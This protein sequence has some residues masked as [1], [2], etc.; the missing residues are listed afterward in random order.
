M[1]DRSRSAPGVTLLTFAPM[2]DSETSRL[3]LRHYGMTYVER[4]HL[5]GWV[6]LL[7]LGHGGFGQV[8]LLYGPGLRLTGPSAITAHFDATAPA[9]R[10]LVRHVEPG[11][12]PKQLTAAIRNDPDWQRFNGGL[13]MYMAVFAYYHLLPHRSAMAPVFAAPVPHG[14]ARLMPMVY[15]LLRGLFAVLLRLSA[16]RASAAGD[17]IRTL[18]DETDRRIADGRPFL[19]GDR[20]SL[21]DIALSGAAAP[22]L[23]PKGFGTIMPP[24]ETTP[25]PMR[26]LFENL[27]ARPTACLVQR[28]YDSLGQ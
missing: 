7:T 28:V 15:P 4:D 5:F 16:S 26:E 12:T 2:V 19:S 27:I 17:H 20:L 13:G 14:E 8:P 6:S 3:L 18:F 11:S 24:I 1:P 21:G 10:R 25:R 23:Q 22:L 9:G